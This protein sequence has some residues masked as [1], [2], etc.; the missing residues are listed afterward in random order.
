M[1]RAKL[2]VSGVLAMVLISVMIIIFLISY[3]YIT[4]QSQRI[5]VLMEER[6]RT[7]SESREIARSISSN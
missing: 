6:Y 3:A 7:L 1:R 5:Q 2:G 4:E